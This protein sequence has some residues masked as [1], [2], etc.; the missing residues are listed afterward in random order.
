[1]NIRD[2]TYRVLEMI[3]PGTEFSSHDLRRTVMNRILYETGQL[4]NPF[5]DTVLRY[6]RERRDLGFV[7]K[8]RRK[9][10]YQKKKEGA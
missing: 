4:R 5:H 10:I 1:V 2:T 7:C 9:S 3:P 6:L 8:S